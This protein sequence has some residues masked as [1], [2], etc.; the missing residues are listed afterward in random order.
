MFEPK[1]YLTAFYA[2]YSKR[3][4][5]LTFFIVKKTVGL[6]GSKIPFLLL[7]VG[8][9]I[10]VTFWYARI[11]FYSGELGVLLMKKFFGRDLFDYFTWRIF[12][13]INLTTLKY[14]SGKSELPSQA[15]VKVQAVMAGILYFFVQ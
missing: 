10:K 8:L 1:N 14:W 9:V 6:R 2:F 7:L 13:I 11:S 4:F 15:Q 5:C 12:L 3:H